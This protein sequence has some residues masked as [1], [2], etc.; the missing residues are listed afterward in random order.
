MRDSA[1]TTSAAGWLALAAL[2][3]ACGGYEGAPAVEDPGAPTAEMLVARH[4]EARGGA[5]RLEGI[6]T[7]SMN[8]RATTGPGREARVSRQVKPP[9][10]IRTEF[11]FQGVTSVYACDGETCWY[12]DPMLGV[13]DAEPMSPA[14]TAWALQEADA[15]S[16]IDWQDGGHRIELRGTD[17]IDGRETYKLQLTL[18]FG[19]SRTVYL[20]AGTAL[21]VRRITPRTRGAKTLEVQTDYGDFREVAG[22]VFPHSIRT[23]ARGSDELLDILVES[24]EVNAPIEDSHFEMPGR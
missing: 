6:E 18:S 8:G 12:V 9:Q 16:A 4:V 23:R 24:I 7:L 10:R 20:D 21:V 2:L 1:I 22:V 19:P 5:E 15:L 14:E 13:F 11:T 3:A 17:T